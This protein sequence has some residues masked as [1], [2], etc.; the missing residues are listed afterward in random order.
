MV[1]AQKQYSDADMNAMPNVNATGLNQAAAANKKAA[2]TKIVKPIDAIKAKYPVGKR[3]NRNP[4][5]KAPTLPVN[6]QSAGT[7]RGANIA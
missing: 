4:K 3:V 5:V 6:R 1:K 2:P 7:V